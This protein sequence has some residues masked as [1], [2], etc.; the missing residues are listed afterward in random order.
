MATN[1]IAS[2]QRLVEDINV[3]LNSAARVNTDAERQMDATLKKSMPMHNH[4]V[5]RRWRSV[6]K[7]NPN[8]AR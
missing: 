8:I 5:N 7:R 6:R 1:K 4:N 3:K 2:Y